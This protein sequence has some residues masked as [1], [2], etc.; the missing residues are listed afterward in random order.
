MK[1]HLLPFLFSLGLA[2]PVLA[3]SPI[4][5]PVHT[6]H[7]PL[8]GGKKDISYVDIA[9]IKTVRGVTYFYYD[10][11]RWE[12]TEHLFG[13]SGAED[14]TSKPSKAVCSEK[15]ITL[16]GPGSIFDPDDWHIRQVNGEWWTELEVI[17]RR[18]KL[19]NDR[20][21]QI[22]GHLSG[23]AYEQNEDR[24]YQAIFD[25]FCGK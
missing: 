16:G 25:T 20:S 11:A 12:G 8:K 6:Y 9:S 2:T 24:T 22:W 10:Y 15:R 17:K 4:W 3:G 21:A 14:K 13:P 18:R 7:F 19:W 1:R 23:L 5:E